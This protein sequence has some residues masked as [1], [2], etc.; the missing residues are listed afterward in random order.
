[1]GCDN[2]FAVIH[3][4][5]GSTMKRTA[6]FAAFAA[7]AAIAM[8][9][10]AETAASASAE[11]VMASSF[12]FDPADST[13]I[14]QKA[15]D[16]GARKIVI[17]RQKS[18]WITRPLF[19]RSNCEIVFEHG[20]EVVAKKGEYLGT[21]DSLLA[22]RSAENVKI[23]GYGATL[24]MHRAD[25]AAAPYQK[26]EWR[27]NI[28]LL[29]CRNVTVEGLT[30]L[31][32]GGDGVYV[33]VDGKNG[34]CRDIVLRDLVCDRHYRQGISV[35]SVCNL[36]IER[37]VLSNTGGTSPSAGID[38]EPNHAREE[39]SG[40]VMKDCVVTDNKGV[41]IEFYLGQL[42]ESSKPISAQIVNC[43]TSGNRSGFWL[44]N[45]RATKTSCVRGEISCENCTF[46]NERG[47][48]IQVKG[49]PKGSVVVSF[50]K[51][52]FYDDQKSSPLLADA[53]VRRK[54]DPA[55][56]RPVDSCPGELMRLKPFRFR[57][58]VT[59]RFYMAKP[60]EA[61]FSGRFTKVGKPEFA[62]KPV[63]VKDAFGRA[64]ASFKLNGGSETPFVFNA[65]AAGFYTMTADAGSHA[66]GLSA[67]SVPIAVVP[68][69]GIRTVYSTEGTLFFRVAADAPFFAAVSGNGEER[70]RAQ[71]AD[72][73]G[74]T[75][76]EG[77]DI[78]NWAAY[79][80]V[81]NPE[82]GLWQITFG[83]PTNHCFEDFSLFQ[84]GA[85]PDLFLTPN[86]CW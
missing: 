12:G 9:V 45:G 30:L 25:Y 78:S 53:P 40:I 49:K 76:W 42:D 80:S 47:S 57:N 34:P 28:K 14:L 11:S 68:T 50:E 16:S 15:L 17:D 74:K 6:L 41:G 36:L 52:H 66:F 26:A 75:V 32:S 10:V 63:V 46:E 72:P 62:P 20:V 21:T 86:K 2:I 43:R 55:A 83:R 51:C 29:S 64:C 60:G 82:E 44:S 59:Y 39:L 18:P 13:E 84:Q 7:A 65:D 81:A 31:E 38:F 48:A 67:T 24:R 85:A 58:G 56:A 5:T 27:M 61:R 1:M 22:F 69:D 79:R 37:C 3:N 4:N 73:S 33:G 19:G 54:F 35:I 70:V 71:I 8:N 23:S 77:D